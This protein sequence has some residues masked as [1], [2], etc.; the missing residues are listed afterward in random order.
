M[1]YTPELQ[2]TR[3]APHMSFESPIEA[4]THKAVDTRRFIG[5][6]NIAL[7]NTPEILHE[8][9]GFSANWTRYML[10]PLERWGLQYLN[11]LIM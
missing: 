6:L 9:L 8:A 4:V 3:M 10:V 1:G 5:F 2:G 11:R 7:C